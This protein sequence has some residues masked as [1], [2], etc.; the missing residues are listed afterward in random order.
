MIGFD[1]GLECVVARR[2][3]QNVK[4]A[5]RHAVINLQP[6]QFSRAPCCAHEVELL[7]LVATLVL[8]LR[9][10]AVLVIA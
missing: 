4:A 9:L 7:F 2:I 8:T 5:A 1:H 6:E 10:R 3:E